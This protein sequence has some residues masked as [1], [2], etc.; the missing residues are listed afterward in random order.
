MLRFL[1]ITNLAISYTMCFT[2]ANAEDLSVLI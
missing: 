1:I 2:Y